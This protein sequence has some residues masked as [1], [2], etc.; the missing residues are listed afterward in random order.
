MHYKKVVTEI[1]LLI[2]TLPWII[3][4]VDH[5]LNI[6]FL[7]RTMG[8]IPTDAFRQLK[9]KRDIDHAKV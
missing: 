5:I 4:N 7:N 8:L 3:N 9:V 1:D 2:I 6:S